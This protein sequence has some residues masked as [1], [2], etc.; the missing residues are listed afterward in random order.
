MHE[1][2]RNIYKKIEL[3]QDDFYFLFASPSLNNIQ[4]KEMP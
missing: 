4:Q 2:K 3:S 1:R